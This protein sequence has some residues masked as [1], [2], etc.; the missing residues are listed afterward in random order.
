MKNA[1]LKLIAIATTANA[2]LTAAQAQAPAGPNRPPTVPAGYLITPFGYFHPSCVVQLAEGDE[3]LPDV[4]LIRHANG[5]SNAMHV[6]AYPH[7]RADGNIVTGDE[8]AVKDPN[9]SHSWIVSESVTTTSSYGFLSAEWSVPPTPPS[10]DDQILY[11][12]PGLEDIKDVVTILQPVLGWNADYP[13]AWGIASWNCCEKGT[14]YKATPERV[15]SGDTILGYMF[16]TCAAGTLSCSSWDVVTR[17]LQNGKVSQLIRTSSFRQTFN[18]AFG[19]VLEVYNV[20]QCSDYPN[21]PNGFNGGGHAISFDE[22]GLYNDKLQ[23]IANPA[24]SL[25]LWATKLTP[26]CSYGGSLPQQVIL[27]Y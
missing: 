17:D 18:W 6:C 20:K 9:I 15:S 13:S 1:F 4:K 14:T 11:Y 19:G 10:N 21:N 2:G 12:F 25:N 8:R 26:Q 23:R 27:T 5:T 7:Y 3:L 24:W 16:D 22:I